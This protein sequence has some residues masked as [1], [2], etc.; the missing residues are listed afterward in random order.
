MSTGGGQELSVSKN[1]ENVEDTN[2]SVKFLTSIAEFMQ[3]LCNKNLQFDTSTL[4]TG[5]LY[6][7]FDNGEKTEFIINEKVCTSDEKDFMFLSNSFDS[8]KNPHKYTNDD[9]TIPSAESSSSKIKTNS[10]ASK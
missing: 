3:S 2:I 5:Q 4:V 8:V 9:S 7:S 10:L 6:L 1:F